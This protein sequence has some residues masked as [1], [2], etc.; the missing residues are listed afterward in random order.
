MSEERDFDAEVKKRITEKTEGKQPADPSIGASGRKLP[1][2]KDG[3]KV[4]QELYK[5]LKDSGQI[6]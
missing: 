1:S 3:F 2:R 5:R 4:G 6:R